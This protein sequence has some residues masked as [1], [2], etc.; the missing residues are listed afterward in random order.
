[1]EGRQGYFAFKE[2]NEEEICKLIKSIKD[3]T[4]TGVDWIDNHCLKLAATELAPAITQIINLSIRTS[5]FPSA[6]KASKLVPI[7]KKDGNPLECN[8]WRPVNQLAVVG[9][10]VERA[11]FGQLVDYLEKNNL[12]HPN[13]HGGREGHSTTTALI[14]MYDR[15]INDMEEG[16]TVAVL[17]IDQSA[18]FD[19][20][21]HTIMLAKLQLILGLG[22]GTNPMMGGLVMKWFN[23]YL[24]DR[25]H[26]TIVEGQMSPL[27]Q[28][29]A[30][31]VIQGGCGAELLYD[32]LTSDLPDCIHQHPRRNFDVPTYCNT[33]GDMTTFVDDSTSY[34]GHKDP[35]VVKDVTQQN[36]NATEEYMNCN[37]LKINGDKSHL[38]VLTKGDSVAGGVAAAQRRETVT[39]KAGGKLIIGSES[40]RLLGGIMHQ[41]GNWRMMIRD[42]K[43]SL[44]KQLAVRI[45][46]LKIISKNAD[47][48]TRKMVAGGLV[49]A[50][51][52]YLLPLFGAAPGYLI[53]TLQVQ[54]LAAAR[55]VL[56]YRCLR[57][58][59]EQMLDA[60]GWLSVRQLHQYSVI[61]LTHKVITTGRPR[62]LH[63]LLVSKFPY[64]TRRAEEREVG[65]Q[66]LP[67]QLRYGEQFGHVSSSSLVGRSFR[68]QAL[69]YNKIP[70]YLRSLKADN[71]K[72]KLKKWIKANVS[73]R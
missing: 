4:S 42:G 73:V 27:L 72:P 47:Q 52:S 45:G 26:C 1:M 13:Q 70:A 71:L 59:T 56:G 20:S 28:L 16:K 46:A 54:Q 19:V 57:W 53:N 62:G 30:C 18:A 11:M 8:S 7:L 58:S 3:S 22:D 39:I 61:M 17:M 6:Y 55:V 32:V 65:M 44:S 29:P 48:K 60:V 41:S 14:E 40:E 37:K 69:V 2:V 43:G 23:S 64:N 38:L 24:S 10:L 50:K 15:W 31:S 9:K 34:F 33:D 68:H 5:V 51:L 21:D 12:L 35:Q 67:R 66:N 49:Q 63:A 25:V 36:F